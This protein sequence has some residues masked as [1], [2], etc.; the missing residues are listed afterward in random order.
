[1]HQPLNPAQQIRMDTAESLTVDQLNR[2]T[3]LL[4]KK[5][6]QGD[7]RRDSPELLA[8]ALQALATNYAATVVVDRD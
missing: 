1:M 7:S 5:F 4:Q 3:A 2:A 6:S 8:A